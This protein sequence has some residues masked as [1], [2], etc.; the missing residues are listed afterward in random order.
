[1]TSKPSPIS[2]LLRFASTCLRY[3]FKEM[4]MTYSCLFSWYCYLIGVKENK[5]KYH[6]TP[7][8]YAGI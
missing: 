3:I 6:K 1:M 2:I 7:Q 8:I 5:C 4:Q